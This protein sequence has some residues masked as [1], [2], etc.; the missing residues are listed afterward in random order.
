MGE[1]AFEGFLE[2][3]LESSLPNVR[4]LLDRLLLENGTRKKALTHVRVALNTSERLPSAFAKP[5]SAGGLHCLL[6]FGGACQGRGNFPFALHTHRLLNELPFHL[7]S[8]VFPS[9]QLEQI[10]IYQSPST[11]MLTF[12]QEMLPYENKPS[13]WLTEEKLL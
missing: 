10:R 12:Y 4:R 5:S 2:G 6:L 1:G 3:F 11:S 7:F 9:S 8:L 13:N